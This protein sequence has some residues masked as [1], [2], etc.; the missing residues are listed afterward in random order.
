MDSFVNITP[1]TRIAALTGAGISA[2]SGVPTFR[3]KEGLWQ[4]YDIMSVA[5]PEGFQRDPRLVW[6]FYNER[7]KEVRSVKPN[8]AHYALARLEN[9]LPEKHFTLITQNIDGLH[10]KA[11]SKNVYHMHGELMKTRCTR[12][13]RVETSLDELPEMPR[14]QCGGLLRPHVVWF[15]EIPF[16]MDTLYRIVEDC[17]LFLVVGTSGAVH[18]AAAFVIHAKGNGAVTA[19]INLEIPEN[20]FYLDHFYRGKAGEILPRLVEHWAGQLKA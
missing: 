6:R 4:K 20:R 3:D 2:E 8:A 12:C 9:L 14:C 7:R 17:D 15:G 1:G 19:G 13:H 16:Q 10:R 11:G 5:T 18:P